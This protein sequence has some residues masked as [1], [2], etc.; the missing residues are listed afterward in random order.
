M[1]RFLFEFEEVVAWCLCFLT[2]NASNLQI[3]LWIRNDRNSNEP[4]VPS[5]RDGRRSSDGDCVSPG[6]GASHHEHSG[7]RLP[8]DASRPNQRGGLAG[9]GPAR[10][11]ASPGARVNYIF[12]DTCRLCFPEYNS[13]TTDLVGSKNLNYSR[14]TI[15]PESM[16][17]ISRRSSWAALHDG[18]WDSL[19]DDPIVHGNPLMLW[20]Q[21]HGKRRLSL[22]EDP[23]SSSK[24]RCHNHTNPT[25]QISR[26]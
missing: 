15:A 8:H 17:V 20:L 19:F 3:L 26:P 12:W 13:V 9:I 21:E 23:N 11:P 25:R 2:E 16:V 24:H 6:C 14:N 4:L 10:P 5:L 7:T 22:G 1:P 18:R